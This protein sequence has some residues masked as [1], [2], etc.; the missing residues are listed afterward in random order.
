MLVSIKFATVKDAKDTVKKV[1]NVKLT[2]KDTDMQLL[3][4]KEKLE[5]KKCSLFKEAKNDLR[6][7]YERY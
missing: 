3:Q 1:K 2:R 6:R 4:N 7:A 5:L